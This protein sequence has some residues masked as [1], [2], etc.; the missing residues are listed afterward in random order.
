MNL[1]IYTNPPT[2]LFLEINRR[3]NLRCNHC[4]FWKRDD[5]GRENYLRQEEIAQIFSEFAQLGGSKIVIC[6]GEPLLDFHR[7]KM[8]CDQAHLAG[9]RVLSVVN[10]TRAPLIDNDFSD[11]FFNGGPDELSVSFDDFRESEHDHFR[12]R[13]GAYA[14]TVSFVDRWKHFRKVTGSTKKITIMYLVHGGN[15]L[16]LERAYDWA[17]NNLGVDKLKL[18]FIQPSFGGASSEQDHTYAQYSLMDFDRLV[19][20]LQGVTKNHGVHFRYQW[21]DA[22]RNYLIPLGQKHPW[23][24]TAGWAAGVETDVPICNSYER[25]IMVSAEGVAQLCFNSQ[26]GGVSL[27]ETSVINFWQNAHDMRSRMSTC[28]AP[29]GISHSV[30]KESCYEVNQ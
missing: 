7:Y 14:S 5:K 4:D 30:R 12:G 25:N 8:V 15:Y 23:F 20:V 29:C 27:R 18:N 16:E 9:L 19:T 26:F 21:L 13:R 10:G 6:G 24:L 28:K 22:V 2:F 1:P 17:L 3:C 11:L